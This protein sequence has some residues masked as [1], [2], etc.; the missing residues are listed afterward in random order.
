MSSMDFAWESGLTNPDLPVYQGHAYQDLLA[1]NDR[2]ESRVL[3]CNAEGEKCYLPILIREIEAGLKEAYSAYGYGGLIGKRKLTHADI[4][5]LREFLAGESILAVFVRHSPFLCNQHCWPESLI[6]V[7]RKT[8]V[9]ALRA[10]DDLDSYITAIPQKLRWSVNYARRAGLQVSFSKLG[11]CSPDQIQKFYRLYAGLMQEKQTGGYYLFSE[12][13]FLQHAQ[14]LGKH[15]ELAEILDPGTGELLAG[16]FFLLDENGW[17]HYHLSA[18]NQNAMRLQGMEL[19]LASAICRYGNLGFH[20]LH[21]GGGHRLDESDGLSR[22]K[23]KFADKQQE[24]CCT[25]LIGDESVY[26]RERGRLPLRNPGLFLISE[27]RKA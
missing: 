9:A 10:Y 6:E 13:F 27:A 12:Q 4:Q 5:S 8:Y 7:N 17:A 1:E 16:A 3:V 19:L 21:L 26:W 24:F 14:K 2:A 22:F 25:K 18:A 23:S 20:S 11:N 15:C